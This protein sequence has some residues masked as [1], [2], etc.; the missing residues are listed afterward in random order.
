MK[1]TQFKKYG[2]PHV[3][4]LVEV[5]EPLDIAGS[6]VIPE[7]IELT[8]N[9]SKVVSIADFTAGDH[10]AQVS[11]GGG[12]RR[13]AL[14]EAARLF[15]VGKLRIPVARTFILNE[16]PA[17]HKASQA[18]HVAGRTVIVID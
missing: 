11:G 7:L 15:E 17:A 6:G 1:A 8:G 14:A 18:G 4:E 2:E 5:D 12:D 13:A 9:A 16:A 3:L 10:G